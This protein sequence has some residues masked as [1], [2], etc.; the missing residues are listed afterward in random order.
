MAFLVGLTYLFFA[1]CADNGFD[2]GRIGAA[3]RDIP[4]VI[5]TFSHAITLM[6]TVIVVAV[7]E[8][9]PMMI[10]VVLSANMRRMINDK[11]MVKKLVGIETAG[12]MNILFTDKTGTLTCGRST[13]SEIITAGGEFTRAAQLKKA[14][15]L[16]RYL[17]ASAILGASAREG[18]ST[19]RALRSFFDNESW[20]SPTVVSSVPFSSDR[21]YSSITLSD[22][23]TVTRG[24]PEIIIASCSESVDG[25]GNRATLKREA[26]IEKYTRAARAGGRVIAVSLTFPDGAVAFAALAVLK[27]KLRPGVRDSVTTVKRAGVSVVMVTGDGKETATAIA[28]ESG[29][30]SGDAKVITHAELEAMSDA[31]LRATIPTLAVVAR[32]LPSDKTRLVRAAQECGLVVG[33]TGDG[34]N[35]APSLKL[36]DVGFAMGSGTD[37]AKSASDIVILD[38][39]LEAICKTVLYG[40]TIFKSIRKFITFQ[41]MMNLTACGISLIGQFIGV[42]NPITIIQMLWINIIMDTL[43]GL[44]FAGEPPLDYYM[45]EKPKP[46]DERILSRDMLHSVMWTGGYTLLI[47]ILFM[48]LDFFKGLFESS[49]GDIR[50]LTGFYALFVFS[51][52]FNCF[53]TR[54]ERLTLLSN[55]GKNK[56][57][58]IIMC[59]I[60][61]IQVLM[62]Y[63]GG[64]IFRC[65]PLSFRELL[66]V[67]LLAS[68]VIPF[69][70]LRR[71]FKKLSRKR[72]NGY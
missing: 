48:K 64:E 36:A 58:I 41:L 7:P 12:S 43:G 65:T 32:A 49:D 24:A 25:E 17:N 51:G 44:A 13:V 52:L 6:I 45:M 47:C 9:L 69:D 19:D 5:S 8:G 21:K 40:R 53:N 33:M 26:I 16:Y 50:F 20:E 27:D 59:A 63:F 68:S 1:F 61:S 42:E 14:P 39:S 60:A 62:V 29:I 23:I 18:N 71:I 4:F 28:R 67:A 56:P 31:E 10:T 57:F 70:G 30:L 11:V 37:I 66:T 35:D 54:S 3:F 15:Y 46:R 22:G 72:E 34:I 2:P 38:D 55:I